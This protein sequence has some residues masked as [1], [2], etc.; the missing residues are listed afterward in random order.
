MFGRSHFTP[1]LPSAILCLGL[2]AGLLA[3]RDAAAE[4]ISFRDDVQPIIAMRCLECHQPGGPGYEATGLDMRTYQSLMEGTRHGPVIVPGDAF[5]STLNALV[6]WRAPAEIRMPHNKKKLT[7][8]EI[9]I[10]RRWV[11]Q[12]AYD[13]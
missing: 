10:F 7:H 6:E 12:G 2:A 11:N 1:K 4:H 13:N 5:A 9:N 8:C 3:P